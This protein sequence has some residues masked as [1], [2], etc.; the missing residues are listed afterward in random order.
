MSLDPELLPASVIV[1]L[2]RRGHSLEDMSEMSV[3][4][5]FA[6]WAASQGIDDPLRVSRALDAI[7]AAWKEPASEASVLPG[8]PWADALSRRE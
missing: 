6:E 7:R 1:T 2:I 3:D 5:A 8:R 4:E